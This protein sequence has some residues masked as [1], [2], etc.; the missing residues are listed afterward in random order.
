VVFAASAAL[1]SPQVTA[2]PGVIFSGAVSGYLRTYATS[3]DSEAP[4]RVTASRR[5][6]LFKANRLE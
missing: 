3:D 2:I 5:S 4:Q 1:R 6:G